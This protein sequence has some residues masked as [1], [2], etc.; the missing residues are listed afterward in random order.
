MS[1]KRAAPSECAEASASEEA[2][3]DCVAEASGREDLHPEG[4]RDEVQS[5]HG[6]LSATTMVWG[7]VEMEECASDGFT[8]AATNVLSFVESLGYFLG[9]ANIFKVITLNNQVYEAASNVGCA[10]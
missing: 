8:L 5:E 10:I 6:T 9:G 7:E 1:L 2:H 3:A 4:G